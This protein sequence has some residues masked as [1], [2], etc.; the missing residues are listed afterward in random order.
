M[1]RVF[2]I[3]ASIVALAALT[4]CGGGGG[5]SAATNTSAVKY[6]QSDLQNATLYGSS[7][8]VGGNNRTARVLMAL[9]QQHL[10]DFSN[11]TTG[12][13]AATNQPCAVAGVGS[14]T[15]GY[16]VTKSAVR[17]GFAAGDQVVLTFSGCDYAGVGLVNDGSITITARAPIAT[18]SAS[19]FNFT[20]DA[21]FTN[22]FQ[23]FGSLRTGYSGL[24]N[25]STNNANA[26]VRTINFIV[27]T[28]PDFLQLTSGVGVFFRPGTAATV[29]QS[30]APATI[31]YKFSGDVSITSLGN[32]NNLR[33]DTTTPIAGPLVS[34]QFSP[35]A[36]VLEV[37]DTG[38]NITTSSTI[39]GNTITV[40]G[41]TDRN[42][43]LDLVFTTTWASLI[44]Q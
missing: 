15:Y 41:D 10:V 17:T 16:A 12:S 4:A 44:G 3:S 13:I 27:P 31:S 40:R 5:D 36:G 28:G 20:F 9:S 8:A 34:G 19:N 22:F 2:S 32:T 35:N 25:A 33:V 37:K 1:I 26:N 6:T 24:L 29:I 42:G 18:A 30:D 23:R 38:L 39:S 43:S 11:Q 21:S 14:G 7:A